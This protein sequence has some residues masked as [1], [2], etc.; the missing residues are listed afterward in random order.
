MDSIKK[1][2]RTSTNPYYVYLAQN[3][4]AKYRFH[5]SELRMEFYLDILQSFAVRGENVIG[6]Y[7]G[8]KFMIAAMVRIQSFSEFLIFESRIIS[9]DFLVRPQFHFQYFEHEC[10]DFM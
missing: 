4:E 2:Y 8:A 3:H 7:C 1:E 5:K 6:V 10:V 9:F